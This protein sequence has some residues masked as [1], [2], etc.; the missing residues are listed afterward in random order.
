MSSNCISVS[1]TLFAYKNEN[2]KILHLSPAIFG[3]QSALGISFL[4]LVSFLLNMKTEI[5]VKCTNSGSFEVCI[6]VRSKFLAGS[7]AKNLIQRINCKWFLGKTFETTVKLLNRSCF[8]QR[9]H[10]DD[11]FLVC[12]WCDICR[13]DCGIRWSLTIL[14]RFSC[15]VFEMGKIAP[16]IKIRN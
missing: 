12:Y 11:T 5:M 6:I 16:K 3:V 7:I 8:L 4:I 13:V 1:L 2:K 15:I 9:L 10:D 14:S